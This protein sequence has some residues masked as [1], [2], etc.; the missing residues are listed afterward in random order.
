MNTSILTNPLPYLGFSV[1]N[2]VYAI[3]I[4]AIGYIALKITVKIVRETFRKMNIPE[5]IVRTIL[6]LVKVIG[7]IVIILGAASALGVETSSVVLG[8]SAIVGLIFGFG[9]Q[10]TIA[11]LAAGVWLAVYRPFNIG[12]AVEIAGKVG[13]VKNISIMAVEL[14]TFDNVYIMI[15]NKSVWGSV[16][17]NYSRNKLRRV[18][19]IIGVAY[20]TDLDKAIRIALETAKNHPDVLKDPEPQVLVGGLGD[21]SINLA[22]RAWTH[23]SKYARVKAELM[24]MLYDSFNKNNIEIPYPQLDIHIRDMPR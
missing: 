5:I 24:K 20:G 19:I 8:F 17:T 11:N 6:N 9:M 3:V 14:H 2:L 23:G 22:V 10:D 4:I 13:V 7:W 16:I 21:S 15:P 18:D 1:I 12:D